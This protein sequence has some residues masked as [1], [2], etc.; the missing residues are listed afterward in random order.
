MEGTQ[1]VAFKF[2]YDSA[3]G[4]YGYRDGADTFCPFSDGSGGGDI[5]ID[6]YDTFVGLSDTTKTFT[7][8]RDYKIVFIQAG[9]S[10]DTNG[11]YGSCNGG[12]IILS[13]SMNL[14]DK[15]QNR[16]Y[17]YINVPTGSVISLTG[18]FCAIQAYGF[19]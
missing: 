1:E 2:E 14:Y 7:T 13:S 18:S 11:S 4:K 16:S 3:S 6:G 9:R 8:T 17:L 5:V 10:R 19:Y 15:A 12:T